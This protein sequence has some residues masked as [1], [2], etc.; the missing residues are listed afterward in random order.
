MVTITGN[1][2]IGEMVQNHPKASGVM[3]KYGLHCVGCHVNQYE[4]VRQGAMGHGMS[5][6]T[7]NSLIL[8]LNEVLNKTIE[9]LEVTPVAR[10]MI[11]SYAKEDKKE[12]FGLKITVMGVPGSFQYDMEFV[13]KESTDDMVFHFDDLKVFVDSES[14]AKLKGS[15][16]DFVQT[17]E[18]AGFRIDNP[19]NKKKGSET[20]A[21]KD[22]SEEDDEANES[23]G[24]G[25]GCH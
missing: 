14:F 3:L 23:C 24:T 2:T 4:S 21:K 18:E 7:L 6:E 12:G 20:S 10:A 22:V 13:E 25:C 9:T 11:K 1:E 8:E 5:E 15:E 19:H 16:I 17:I